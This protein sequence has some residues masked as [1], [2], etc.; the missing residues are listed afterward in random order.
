MTPKPLLPLRDQLALDRTDL[1][2]RR[3]WLASA[4]TALAMFVSGVSFLEIFEADW[5]RI[6]GWCLATLSAPVLSLGYWRFH[7]EQRQLN[8]LEEDARRRM[9]EVEATTPPGGPAPG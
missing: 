4:R 7:H 6:A 9:I 3:T 8:Q 2:N 5:V 1:A